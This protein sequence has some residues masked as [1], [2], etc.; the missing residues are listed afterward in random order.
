VLNFNGVEFVRAV[1]ASQKLLKAI[2]ERLCKIVLSR[3]RFSDG[4]S[5]G[6]IAGARIGLLQR[7]P[8]L[9]THGVLSAKCPLYETHMNAT[10]VLALRSAG[11]RFR[12]NCLKSRSILI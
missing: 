10:C 5:D 12:P 11:V 6:A 2:G 8:D 3:E 9:A 4:C 1:E 7:Y